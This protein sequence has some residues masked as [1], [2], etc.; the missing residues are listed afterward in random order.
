MM[1]LPA[2]AEGQMFFFTAHL[3]V[4][5]SLLCKPFRAV[6]VMERCYVFLKRLCQVLCAL[7]GQLFS[8]LVS[9]SIGFS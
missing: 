3:D 8:L 5:Y 1:H 4:T 7:G 6:V 9:L 2:E